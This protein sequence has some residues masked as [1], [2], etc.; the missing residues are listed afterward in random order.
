MVE[1][2]VVL[3]NRLSI[4]KANPLKLFFYLNLDNDKPA[5]CGKKV[6]QECIVEY[7]ILFTK[8]K[9]CAGIERYIRCLREKADQY[10]CNAPI[11]KRLIRANVIFKNAVHEIHEEDSED[12]VFQ[13]ANS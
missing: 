6:A 10:S 5:L 7:N 12:C 13:T 8:G 11:M 3:D 9:L 1:T 2:C 4:S